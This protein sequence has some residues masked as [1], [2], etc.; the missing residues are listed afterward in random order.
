M[1]KTFKKSSLIFIALNALTFTVFSACSQN[2]DFD[3]TWCEN[4]INTL[5]KRSMGQGGESTEPT[6]PTVSS[7]EVEVTLYEEY[8]KD[9]FSRRS[10]T[11]TVQYTL[12]QYED[13]SID[14]S[15]G[16]VTTGSIEY[17]VNATSISAGIL[18]GHY[19][20]YCRGN[21]IDGNTYSG[22]TEFIH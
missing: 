12:T 8:P 7:G 2:D 15:V 18:S 10:F 9:Y 17:S 20:V 3:E 1:N 13:E 19:I 5:A 6:E 11:A 16:M 22:K 21:D 4:E 14:I